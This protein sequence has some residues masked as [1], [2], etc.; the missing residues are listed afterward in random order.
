M[1]FL[2]IKLT[3]FFAQANAICALDCLLS[4]LLAEFTYTRG[5]I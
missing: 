2:K 1:G 5:T 4:P 3:N